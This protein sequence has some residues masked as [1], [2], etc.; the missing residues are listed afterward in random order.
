MKIQDVI[1]YIFQVLA[2]VLF[3][4]QLHQSVRKYLR[5]P[6]VVETSQV[7]VDSLQAEI[8]ETLLIEILKKY[9]FKNVSSLMIHK[10]LRNSE[11]VRLR[12]FSFFLSSTFIY[13]PILIK[14]IY[15]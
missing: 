8:R 12:G 6:V 11:T 14:K 10:K 3:L 15:E 9:L 7:P 1:R 5:H 4:I 2:L 13:Q